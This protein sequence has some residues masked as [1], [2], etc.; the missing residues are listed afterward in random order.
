MPKNAMAQGAGSPV[1]VTVLSGC[2]CL[3]RQLCPVLAATC[4]AHH[5]TDTEIL[6]IHNYFINRKTLRTCRRALAFIV[7]YARQTQK[8]T[9]GA[10]IRI[11]SMSN[12][13]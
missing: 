13:K 8:K 11:M 7:Y 12:Q 2:Q 1:D 9:E 3:I 6:F 5:P 4:L 10:S